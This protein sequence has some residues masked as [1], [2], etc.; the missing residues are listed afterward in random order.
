MDEILLNLIVES[1]RFLRASANACEKMDAGYV[2]SYEGRIRWF[3]ARLKEALAAGNWKIVEL[4]NQPYDPGMA[5]LIINME[6]FEPGDALFV[7]KMIEPIIMADSGVV[8]M[9]KAL[10][11]RGS[12]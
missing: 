4:E 1:W 2:R 3:D 11:R 10:V 7:D 9:G 6:D 8:R 12:V 5:L